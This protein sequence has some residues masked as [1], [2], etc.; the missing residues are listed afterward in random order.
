MRNSTKTN[1]EQRIDW[2][3]GVASRR[4]KIPKQV[5][6][7]LLNLRE[8]C[9]LTIANSFDQISYNTLKQSSSALFPRDN[10][11]IR[12][13]GW[14]TLKDLLEQARRVCAPDPTPSPKDP[15]PPPKEI[16]DR[17]LLDAH[18]CSMAYIE[19]YNFLKMLS[20]Q[21]IPPGMKKTI[22]RQLEITTARFKLIIS[23]SDNF[24]PPNKPLRAV[25]TGEH[26]ES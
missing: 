1:V 2:L 21:D 22:D 18:I 24:A 4:I 16:L 13:N 8:F 19:L 25:A 26:N 14:T 23:H 10:P 20:R 11:L 9:K 7:S 5:Y 12:E 3:S 15:L 6:R 17:T